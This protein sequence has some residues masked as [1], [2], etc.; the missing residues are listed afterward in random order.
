MNWGKSIALVY[1]IF[2]VSMIGVTVY[3]STLDINLVTPEYYADELKYE[4]QI[5]KQQNANQLPV[6]LQIDYQAEGRN[7][8]LTFPADMKDVKGEIKLYR[9]SN[10]R[11]DQSIPVALTDQVQAISASELQQGLWRVK[12]EWEAAEGAYFQEKSIFVQ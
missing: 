11:L 1:T 3:C 4:A 12:V 9:P 2:A 8:L 6:P 7:I 5:A 10:S